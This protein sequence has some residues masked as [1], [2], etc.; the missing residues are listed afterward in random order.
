MKLALKV[1]DQQNNK[2]EVVAQFADFIAWE[3]EHN[4]SLSTFEAE[5][6]LRDLC[7]L[8]WHVEHRNKVT[9][10]SFADWMNDVALIEPAE[11]G[12]VIVPLESQ[13]HTG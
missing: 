13:A 6:K 4:R 2:R 9:I 12:S 7:W 3:A 10:A 11:D 5:M 8:A 1:T